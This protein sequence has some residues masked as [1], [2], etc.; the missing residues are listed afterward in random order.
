MVLAPDDD[1]PIE[2]HPYWYG[3]IA[4]IFHVDVRCSANGSEEEPQRVDVLWVRW[5]WRDTLRIRVL[6]GSPIVVSIV[7]VSWMHQTQRHQG[8]L[9]LISSF[10]PYTSFQLSR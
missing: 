6:A 7:S 9:I 3:R 5:F 10:V 4:R 1:S 8:S 2:P